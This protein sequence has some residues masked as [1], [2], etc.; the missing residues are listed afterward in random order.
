MS[1]SDDEN[2]S[3]QFCA[4]CRRP[5]KSED[6]TCR[7]CGAVLESEIRKDG[8]KIFTDFVERW[9]KLDKTEQMTP[10]MIS[11]PEE[12]IPSR[13]SVR[14]RRCE[15]LL[16]KNPN[17]PKAWFGKGMVLFEMDR[18]E[19]ALDCLETATML[20]PKHKEA[21]N[22]KA[23]IYT[24]L[25]RH[26]ES[27]DCYKKALEITSGR[28]DGIH[29]E[30]GTEEQSFKDILEEVGEEE[31]EEGFLKELRQYE[32]RL[33]NDPN[34]K[35]ALYYK[36]HALI[37][38]ERYKEAMNFLHSLTRLDMNYPGIWQTKGDVFKELGDDRN[39]AL[40]YKKAMETLPEQYACPI[41][42]NFVDADITR[43]PRCGSVFEGED[44]KELE[45]Q[46][47]IEEL[48]VTPEPK[49]EPPRQTI[50][51]QSLNQSPNLLVLQFPSH[52][53][54]VLLLQNQRFLRIYCTNPFCFA[55]LKQNPLSAR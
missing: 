32:E 19:E 9:E 21:W 15:R 27:A 1:D 36:A 29:K 18:Y 52:R 2:K 54:H 23:S 13:Y 8:K 24:R 44:D 55:R 31:E 47:E 34:D 51:N 40:C 38:L 6:T 37:K 43:C 16:E 28:I 35:D 39:A 10:S 46:Q 17:D 12:E 41:C 25:G 30:I 26:Q 3:T 5:V 22:I 14:L 7:F 48:A 33:K 20:D 50:P 53:F 4:V 42:G 49:P 11:L 45:I